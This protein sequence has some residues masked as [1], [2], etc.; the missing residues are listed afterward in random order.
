MGHTLDM[1]KEVPGAII[2]TRAEPPQS[3]LSPAKQPVGVPRI[4][5]APSLNL[6][7]QI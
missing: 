6:P 2:L 7:A 3:N 1:L 4:F 5:P